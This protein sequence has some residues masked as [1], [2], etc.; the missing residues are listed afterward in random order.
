MFKSTR[1]I[2]SFAIATLLCSFSLSALAAGETFTVAGVTFI[3]PGKWEKVAPSSS[4]RAAQ[5]AIRDGNAKADAVFFYF[6]QGGG[7]VDA[8]VDRWLKQFK[9]PKD[10]INAK[11]E[12]KKV[13]NTKVTYV[14]A[15]GTFMEG[16]RPFGPK[17][18]MPGYALLGII[19]EG[20]EGSIF[21]KMTGP[22][23]IV[24]SSK[25]AARKMVEDALK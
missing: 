10:K 3:R 24:D 22:K 11:I 16:S 18:P 15:E 14:E 2:R 21:I 9:E 1:L 23:K 7:G 20:P 12:A 25:K 4:M 5:F 6:G 17:T 19:I 8:N 13:G